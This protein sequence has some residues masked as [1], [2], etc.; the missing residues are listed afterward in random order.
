ML[1]D[2]SSQYLETG[3][4]LLLQVMRQNTNFYILLRAEN[5]SSFQ[6][7]SKNLR[8]LRLGVSALI[9]SKITREMNEVL[10]L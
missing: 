9:A 3:L 8:R 1:I 6:F 7:N 5:K 2:Q 10:V 4:F